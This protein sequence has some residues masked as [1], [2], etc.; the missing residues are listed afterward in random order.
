[1]KIRVGFVSN[2]SSSSFILNKV[3]LT[4]SQIAILKKHDNFIKNFLDHND[5]T[6]LGFDEDTGWFVYEEDNFIKLSTTMDNFDMVNFLR[7][8]GADRAIENMEYSYR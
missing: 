1:M 2:S 4:N 7:F 5:K 3:F 6:M 8:I